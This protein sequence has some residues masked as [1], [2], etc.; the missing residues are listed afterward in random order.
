MGGIEMNAV[1]QQIADAFK[2]FGWSCGSEFWKR[3]YSDAWI[4]NLTNAIVALTF[5]EAMPDADR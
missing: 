2:P 3:Y 4:Y 5:G 1:E